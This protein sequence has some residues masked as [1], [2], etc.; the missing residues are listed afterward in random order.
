MYK[1]IDL[2]VSVQETGE[3]RVRLLDSVLTKTAFTEIQAFWDTLE[4]S[5]GAAY[6]W[7]IGVSAMEFYGC[8]NNGDAFS[9]EDLKKTH[10]DFVSNAHVFLHHINK[11]PNKAVGKPI[12]SWYNE[13]MHRV[14]LI[15]KIDK[16]LQGADGIIDKIQR[17]EQ[18]F[19]SM[20]CTVRYDVC[21]ICGNKAPTR[22]DYCDHLR[23]NMKKILPDGKQVY[24][25]NPNPKFFDISIVNRPA[26][27]TAFTLD[28]LASE[29]A[30][31]LQ[32]S[33]S[34]A[35]GELASNSALK[36]AALRK[37]SD[38]IKEVDGTVVDTK[39]SCPEAGVARHLLESGFDSMDY[40]ELRPDM[41]ASLRLSPGGLAALL[42]HLGSPITL[43]DAAW[44]AGRH[45]F[46]EHLSPR[47]ISDMFLCLPRALELLRQSPDAVDD[48]LHD[49]LS[50]YT[51][52]LDLPGHRTLII[53]CVKPVVT[54]RILLITKL[55][56]PQQLQKLAANF[57]PTLPSAMI[58]NNS[59]SGENFTPI[60]LA[61]GR[62]TS[63]YHIHQATITSGTEGAAYKALGAALALGAIGSA[64]VSPDLSHKLLY[65][66]ILGLP[67]AALLMAGNAESSVVGE[68]IPATTLMQA[69]KQEKKA[70]VEK[71]PRLGTLGGMAIPA[72]LAMDYAYNKWRYGN[73]PVEM[74]ERLTP[75]GR[76]AN[77]AGE[78][79]F[80][81]PL[82]SIAVG[83]LLGSRFHS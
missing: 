42:T 47:H 7:V 62:K 26:D 67:A 4:H 21:S 68:E 40:P 27:P 72:A 31:Y 15:L 59:Q 16:T 48:H 36:T 82:T 76:L 10:T 79:V 56:S 71:M 49:V 57:A 50:N 60:I 19:V 77:R 43:G 63:P 14:E 69:W 44:M 83:G 28:K 5:D 33:S 66:S 2:G 23:F 53:K 46:G 30:E 80:N 35:I 73:D 64:A 65:A 37:L 45:H 54:S 38:I 13:P 29:G 51:G 1:V 25:F 8:N 39:D 3:P 81:N 41:L 9:E 18:L 17:G 6:L 55:A 78:I 24:A 70:S 75:F 22:N 20:G 11:D 52:E 12:Y 58:R 74:H 61:D 32:T 34:A